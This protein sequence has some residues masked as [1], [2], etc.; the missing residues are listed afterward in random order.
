MR[1]TH[2]GGR[3]AERRT[4]RPREQRRRHE[5]VDVLQ[6]LCR[7]RLVPVLHHPQLALRCSQPLDRVSDVG[8]HR[9]TEQQNPIAVGAGLFGGAHRHRHLRD[10]RFVRQLVVLEQPPPHCAGAQRDHDAV[11]GAL[12]RRLYRLH[13]VQIHLAEREPAMRRDLAVE[14]RLGC[15]QP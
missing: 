9:R 8:E 5:V 2:T 6:Q 13:A 12:V 4:R 3:K 1:P 11:D 7:H 10:Q 14:R 15:V